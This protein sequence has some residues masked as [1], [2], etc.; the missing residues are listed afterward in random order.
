MPALS[1]P[2]LEQITATPLVGDRTYQAIR[3][4]ILSRV[5]APGSKLTVDVVAKRLG[6]SRTPVKEA[7]V[8]LERE[9]LVRMVP[10]H[11]AFVATLAPE[12]V[13]EIYDLREVLEGLAAR[14]AAQRV[15]RQHLARLATLLRKT[16]AHAAAGD[17]TLYSDVDLLFHQTIREASGSPRLI[18]TLENLRG[19]VR[20]LMSTSIVLPGRLEKS[21]QEHRRIYEA[22][23]RRDPEAAEEAARAHMRASREAMA[24]YLSQQPL[25]GSRSQTLPTLPQEA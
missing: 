19:Q 15:T 21:V 4:A 13:L 7:L 1:P 6:V 20:L 17:L 23:K 8:R 12:E 11:G 5:F 25:P 2:D 3:D 10:R 22:L 18:D 14:K 24:S 16:E 9:G